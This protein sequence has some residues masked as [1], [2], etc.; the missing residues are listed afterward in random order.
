MS[1]KDF[2]PGVLREQIP[3]HTINRRTSTAIEHPTFDLVNRELKVGDF[4]EFQI[5]IPYLP[6]INSLNNKIT[7]NDTNYTITSG[8]N[9]TSNAQIIT[10]F[11]TA[12]AGTGCVL[13]LQPETN[14][15][16]IEHS[17]TNFTLKACPFLGFKSDRSGN[18][19]Y[20]ADEPFDITENMIYVCSDFSTNLEMV[21]P[22]LNV[23]SWLPS[24]LL[25]AT[26][27]YAGGGH[28][29]AATSNLFRINKNFSFRQINFSLRNP[30]SPTVDIPINQHWGVIIKIYRS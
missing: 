19:I 23:E 1:K 10:A 26:I 11:N 4:I 14:I 17:D 3:L 28:R 29:F 22:S 15:I 27:H 25:F 12:I 6:V 16:K 21:T 13:T 30:S 5:D 2:Y 7:I 18:T 24:D 20:Q 9:Y 8:I